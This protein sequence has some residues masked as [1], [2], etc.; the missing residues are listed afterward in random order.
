ME[1]QEVMRME[2]AKKISEELNEKYEIDRVAGLI[3]DNKIAFTHKEDEYR[4][5][6]LTQKDKDDLDMLRRKKFG[7]LLQDKDILLEKDLIKIYKERGIDISEIDDKINKIN[8]EMHSKQLKLGESLSKDSDKSILNTYKNEIKDLINQKGA[9]Y[10]QKSGLLE[11]SLEKQLEYFTIK[12][13][14]YLSLQI[15]KDEI[16][17]RA[18]DDIDKFL[19]A[20]DELIEKTVSYSLT[21]NYQI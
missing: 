11:F 5:R 3:K 7:Q 13:I 18:F 21:I 17:I 12:I 10:L 4:V 20:D 19:N 6:L 8:T 2:E 9:L 16:F 14:S 1:N 15:K